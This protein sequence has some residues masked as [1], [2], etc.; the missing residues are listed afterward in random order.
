MRCAVQVIGPCW[1]LQSRQKFRESKYYP[2]WVGWFHLCVGLGVDPWWDNH[3]VTG[4]KRCHKRVFK[5]NKKLIGGDWGISLGGFRRFPY[6]RVHNCSGRRAKV[7]DDGGH[8]VDLDS[9]GFIPARRG[10]AGLVQVAV[11][12]D[13]TQEAKTSQLGQGLDNAVQDGIIPQLRLPEFDDGNMRKLV[14]GFFGLLRRT[15]DES[16]CI[17]DGPD[18]SRQSIRD[19]MLGDVVLGDGPGGFR[20]K[21]L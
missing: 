4:S 5:P 14:E 18:S 3:Q 9:R 11:D 17:L 1:K 10:A 2:V 13:D 21:G 6:S 16:W 19:I 15:L 7:S 8:P 12:D 20:P